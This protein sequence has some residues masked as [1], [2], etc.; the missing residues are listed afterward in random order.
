M[1]GLRRSPTGAGLGTRKLSKSVPARIFGSANQQ[2][3][4]GSKRVANAF[5]GNPYI[6]GIQVDTDEATSHPLCDRTGGTGS[7]ER[8]EN[9]LT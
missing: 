3:G 9:D 2:Q 8:V 5:A 4:W 7:D 1:L 6:S